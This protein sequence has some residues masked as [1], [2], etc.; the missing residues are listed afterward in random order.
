MFLTY[1]VKMPSCDRK[2]RDANRD[3]CQRW[4][5]ENASRNA[6]FNAAW[7]KENPDKVAAQNKRYQQQHSKL[8]TCRQKMYRQRHPEKAA[9]MVKCWRQMNRRKSAFIA[10]CWRERNPEKAAAITNRYRQRNMA[11]LLSSLRKWYK[12]NCDRKCSNRRM[13]YQK[14]C[15]HERSQIRRQRYRLNLAIDSQYYR[16]KNIILLRAGEAAV[17][18]A[19]VKKVA[20]SITRACKRRRDAIVFHEAKILVAAAMNIRQKNVMGLKRALARLKSHCDG[21]SGKVGDDSGA[22]T[23]DTLCGTGL[24][25]RSGP[26]GQKPHMNFRKVVEYK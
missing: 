3:A 9:V 12:K 21:I 1:F 26:G 17:Q 2:K 19:F 15:M 7:R 25:S 14:Q 10:K 23:L 8:N 16:N 18:M 13:A 6:C 20:T 11:K 24:H 22:Y 5:T 4:K